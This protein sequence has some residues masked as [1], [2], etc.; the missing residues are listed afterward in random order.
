VILTFSE[1]LLKSCKIPGEFFEGFPDI[2]I[3]NLKFLEDFPDV[4]IKNFR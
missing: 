1:C 3:K 2:F 4:F